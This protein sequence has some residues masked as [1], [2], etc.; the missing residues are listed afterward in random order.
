MLS[1]SG[2]TRSRIWVR[3]LP[4][5]VLSAL[6]ATAA[7]AAAHQTKTAGKFTIDGF[8]LTGEPVMA[9][10]QT[11]FE[12]TLAEGKP[13]DEGGKPVVLSDRELKLLA[14]HVFVGA[15]KATPALAAKQPGG[16]PLALPVHA[17]P[18]EGPGT[19]KSD[20]ISFTAPGPYTAHL[21]S[22]LKGVAG[23]TKTV[24]LRGQVVD[25]Q[26]PMGP[27]SYGPVENP[28]SIMWP[29]KVPTNAELAGKITR[30]EQRDATAAPRMT[31]M[32]A[33]AEN[34]AEELDQTRLLL[35]GAIL[36][37]LIALVVAALAW[38]RRGAGRGGSGGT[39]DREDAQ[40]G[41]FHRL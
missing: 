36:V 27:N 39:R 1:S 20:P 30:M 38:G 9:G 10:E 41:E 21:H 16:K 28:T 24:P 35:W 5:L 26:F 11:E 18:W 33:T 12:F 32:I 34:T 13:V 2:R 23:A 25:V 4:L 17:T 37:A 31:G 40:V 14:L 7:P 6:L 22:P 8:G 15:V 29:A 19:Y 3:V